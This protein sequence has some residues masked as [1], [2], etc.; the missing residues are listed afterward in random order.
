MAGPQVRPEGSEVVGQASALRGNSENVNQGVA[1]RDDGYANRPA[2]CILW[3]GV[4][5]SVMHK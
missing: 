1:A 4:M 5:T 3:L 2:R